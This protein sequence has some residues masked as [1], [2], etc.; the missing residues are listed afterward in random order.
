M[1]TH[2]NVDRLGALIYVI[3]ALFL[4]FKAVP[5]N[6]E[7]ELNLWNSKPISKLRRAVK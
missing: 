7:E 2:L 6:Y 1:Q 4:H 3:G 5:S